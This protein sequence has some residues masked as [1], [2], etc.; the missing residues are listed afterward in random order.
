[1]KL[2][3]AQMNRIQQI[4]KNNNPRD[5]NLKVNYILIQV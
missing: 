1:M 2:R 4:E 3:E 5:F